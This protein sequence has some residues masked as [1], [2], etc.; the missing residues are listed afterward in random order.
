MQ[1]K[2]KRKGKRKKKG[3][4]EQEIKKPTNTR[5]GGV[6]RG[7]GERDGGGALHLISKN[8][9]YELIPLLIK[10]G[11]DV[12]AVNDKGFSSLNY[13]FECLTF[14]DLSQKLILT[15]KALIDHGADVNIR[16]K[17][18]LETVVHKVAALTGGLEI[19][20]YIIK[21][22]IKKTNFNIR[23]VF[24]RTPL[25]FI[26]HNPNGIEMLKICIKNQNKI[27]INE[28]IIKRVI[29]KPNCKNEIKKFL[30]TYQ[31]LQNDF[32]QLTLNGK[33]NSFE[34]D[35]VINNS[36]KDFHLHKWIIKMRFYNCLNNTNDDDDDDEKKNKNNNKN[37]K[38]N[39][40]D[41]EFF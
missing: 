11:L 6:G 30:L 24:N 15:I 8:Q 7:D 36:V 28:G 21:K 27:N 17:I 2:K 18:T 9:Y 14:G 33:E 3:E 4:I 29:A 19:F 34:T 22:S 13:I 41:K 1:K 20:K 10:K 38:K 26:T 40:D 32:L 5:T 37:N 23:D 31:S 35:L 39:N 12:N 16:S 25:D